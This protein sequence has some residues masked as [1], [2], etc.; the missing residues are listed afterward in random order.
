MSEVFIDIL[1]ILGT[2]SFSGGIVWIVAKAVDTLVF[3][4][5]DE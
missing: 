3:R 2:A 5:R 1:L 4:G